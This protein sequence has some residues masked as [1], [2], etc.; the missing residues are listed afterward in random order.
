MQVFIPS[1]RAG[2]YVSFVCI[3]SDAARYLMHHCTLA[4]YD[5][6]LLRRSA[7]LRVWPTESD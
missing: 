5:G 4:V 3:A 7:C 1:E 6:K 2:R